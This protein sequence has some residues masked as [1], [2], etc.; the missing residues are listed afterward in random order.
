MNTSIPMSSGAFDPSQSPHHASAGA[1]D[2]DLLLLTE[3]QSPVFDIV[4]VWALIYRNRVVMGLI[5]AL[6]LAML[7][8]TVPL[9]LL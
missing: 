3:A 5:V 7:S 2:E 9:A 6:A 4:G 8:E 1:S